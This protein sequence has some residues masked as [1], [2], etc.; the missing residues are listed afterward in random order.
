MSITYIDEE[1]L[2]NFAC[3]MVEQARKDFIKGGKV[4]YGVLHAIPTQKEL[5]ADPTHVSLTNDADVRW[6]Y[7]A[8]RFVTEDPYKFF[9]DVGEEAV[10][11]A[12]TKESIKEYYKVSYIKGATILYINH[13][14]KYIHALPD[15]E[16][17]EIMKDNKLASEFLKAREYISS[18][19]D[20]DDIFREWNVMALARSRKRYYRH[21]AG[22]DPDYKTHP[23]KLKDARQRNI[24]TAKEL[25]ESG[26]SERAIAKYLDVQVN[27]VM[28]YLRS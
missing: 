3:A 15:K 14:K 2:G 11:K 10:I 20:K 19:D 8:W 5:L 1:G 7:D 4:L 23:E 24:N 6:M 28:N 17:I 9:G 13:S 25:F 21:L 22:V 16:I 12:W 27:T 26:M 18:L